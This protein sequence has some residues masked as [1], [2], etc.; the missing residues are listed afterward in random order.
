[1]VPMLCVGTG[2]DAEYLLTA[3]PRRSMGSIN[4]QSSISSRHKN[5][6]ANWLLCF[7][8]RLD[9]SG[10]VTAIHVQR[11]AG[12]IARGIA[13]EIEHRTGHFARVGD[14]VQREM[15]QRL[16]ADRV[17]LDQGRGELCIRE[18]WQQGVTANSQRCAFL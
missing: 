2:M 10:E 1:M 9:Q 16:L 6:G 11:N 18:A 4:H 14:T 7:V 15:L 5:K 8:A 3:S 12:G 13:G 17:V